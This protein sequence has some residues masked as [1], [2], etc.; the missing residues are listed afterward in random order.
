MQLDIYDTANILLLGATVAFILAAI[1][2]KELV[3]ASIAL[4]IG[5]ALLS[6]VFYAI[7]APIAGVFELSVCAGLV[8]ILLIS[9]IGMTEKNEGSE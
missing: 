9:A 7:N 5:S 4:G 8:T 6:V 2:L 3:K 1:E